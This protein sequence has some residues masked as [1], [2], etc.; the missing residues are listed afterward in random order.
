MTIFGGK[1]EKI[2]NLKNWGEICTDFRPHS[3]EIVITIQ[4][5]TDLG[6][7]R[8]SESDFS[9]GIQRAVDVPRGL[10]RFQAGLQFHRYRP[11]VGTESL[12]TARICGPFARPEDLD[13]RHFLPYGS[14]QKGKR[15]GG[16]RIMMMMMMM[17]MISVMMMVIGDDDDGD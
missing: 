7:K 5:E 2:Q 9:S 6:P 1:F 3:S 14:F 17:M 13:A 8:Y 15:Q 12:E 4:K 10:G 16:M 11:P